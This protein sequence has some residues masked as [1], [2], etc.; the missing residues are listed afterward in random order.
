LTKEPPLKS[1]VLCQFFHKTLSLVLINFS[2]PWETPEV[3]LILQ[4]YPKFWNQ[5]FF[6]SEIFQKN[7]ELSDYLF[8]GFWQNFDLEN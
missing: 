3:I 8:G 2:N 4:N 5:M 6:D 1:P 7:Q